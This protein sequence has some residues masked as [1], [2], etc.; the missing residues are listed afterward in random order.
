V[1]EQGVARGPAAVEVAEEA[2]REGVA[3]AG[4]VHDVLE[5]VAGDGEELVAGEKGRAVLASLGDDHLGTHIHRCAGRAGQIRLARQ[6][7]DLGVVQQQAVDL[8][9]RRLQRVPRRVEPEVHRVQ[10]H[11]LGSLTGSPDLELEIGLDVAE[12]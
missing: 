10:A 8:G 6:L 4:R 2:A 1:V 5:H 12:E 7:A 3:G 9:D 11:E